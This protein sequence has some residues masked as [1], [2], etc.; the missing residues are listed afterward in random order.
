MG[1][2]MGRGGGHAIFVSCMERKFGTDLYLYGEY[3][4]SAL[5]IKHH[6]AQNI[7]FKENICAKTM[8]LLMDPDEVWCLN[9]YK[10]FR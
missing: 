9:V 1:H 7:K 10:F 5:T 3:R 4:Q 6:Q 2:E 8:I